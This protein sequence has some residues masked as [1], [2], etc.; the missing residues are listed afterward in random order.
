MATVDIRLQAENQA[1]REVLELRQQMVDLNRALDRQKR[2]LAS[3]TATEKQSVR[4]RIEATQALRQQN[5]RRQQQLSVV[6]AQIAQ[7]ARE[8]KQTEALAR[9]QERLSQ[10][11]RRSTRDF[12]T[13]ISSLANASFVYYAIRTAIVR[14]VQS[15]IRVS[16]EAE[17]F[18]SVLKFTTTDAAATAREIRALN[19]EL[20]LTDFS[21][22]TRAFNA[23]NAAS[24]DA[25]L[26]IDIIRGFGTAMGTLN[27]AAS[28]Q[29]RFFTQLSQA[30]AQNTGLRL[31][32]LKI[33]QETL[34]SLLNISSRALGQQVSSFEQLKEV[35]ESSNLSAR[36]YFQTLSDFSGT[37]LP[38][39]DT[40]TYTAQRELLSEDLRQLQRQIG[41]GL[42]PS[43][44][45]WYS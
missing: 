43:I 13:F 22:I 41:Q 23:L 30:Y 7:M 4:T 18:N 34:P 20:V 15:T 6:K 32:K 37:N 40:T 14:V 10:S 35:L 16:A 21:T 29:E 8:Q 3:A 5:L 25:Q 12:G 36:Q 33:L 2:Q 11:T 24:G 19:R 26:S 17:R 9:E 38:G 42:R 1:S 31:T 44:G 28:D 45:L 39:A 27:V